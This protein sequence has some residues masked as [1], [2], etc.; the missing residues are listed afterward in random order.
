VANEVAYALEHDKPVYRTDWR[1]GE[2]VKV[3]EVGKALTIEESRLLVDAIVYLLL[4][5]VELA[6]LLKTIMERVPLQYNLYY[7][8]RSKHQAS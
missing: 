7:H 1:T 6:N 4:D 8:R 2:I 3:N 5:D